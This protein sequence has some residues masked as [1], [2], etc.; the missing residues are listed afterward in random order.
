M[1]VILES[2]EFYVKLNHQIKKLLANSENKY[3]IHNLNVFC[4]EKVQERIANNIDIFNNW[5]DNEINDLYNFNVVS[6]NE[7]YK[8]DEAKEIIEDFKKVE[9]YN[10]KL[11][12]K[13]LIQL[14]QNLNFINYQIEC[15]YND[16]FL[17]FIQWC[18][19]RVY[20]QNEIE[21]ING[22]YEKLED[23][24]KYGIHWGEW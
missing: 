10:Y 4:S 11:S 3:L 24:F 23:Q 20:F 17:K 13:E 9:F 7:R 19:S 8:E 22:R 18:I 2:K 21:I 16:N 14:Y 12:Q 6:Y 5:I 1:S 15:K